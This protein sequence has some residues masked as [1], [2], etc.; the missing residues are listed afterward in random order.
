MLAEKRPKASFDHSYG[1]P[2]CVNALPTS[3]MSSAYGS[4]NMTA[5]TISQVKPSPP[6]E[7]T[8][9]SV[10]RPTNA[11]SV[12]KS[13]SKRRSAFLSFFFSASASS[14]VCSTG[15][16]CAATA[17]TCLLRVSR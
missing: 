5:S 14:V 10:S 1:P 6:Y 13:M 11:Q 8:I 12:K 3:D 4:T 2:S 17:M 7:A 16:W 9:P 15:C